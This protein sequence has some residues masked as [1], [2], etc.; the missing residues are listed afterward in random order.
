MISI[1]TSQ[2]IEI[3]ARAG[4]ILAKIMRELKDKVEPGMTTNELDKL[5]QELIFIYGVKSAFKGYQGFPNVLCT[6]VNEQIV[7]AM[8]SDRELKQ[9][10]ILSLDMGIIYP[11]GRGKYGFYSDMAVTV[12]I[13]AIDPEVNRLIR[14][15]KKALKRGIGRVK[16]GK[17]LGDIGHAIQRYI[18]DQDF[19]VIKE[20]CG[21]GIG[22]QLQEEPEVLNFGQRHKGEVLKPGMVLA[23][24]PMAVMGNPG[25][26]KCLE[27][28]NICYQ[29]IDNSLSAHFEHTVAVTDK[30]PRILTE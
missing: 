15:T 18:E 8:P 7:H 6:S 25:I 14:V 9:G 2:E 13:G 3:M 23:L 19:H 26:K 17:T 16:P 12:P 22:K 20:L 4:K 5:A 1:K 29:T 21:H 11:A 28:G 10:D 27:G 24:E 30:G